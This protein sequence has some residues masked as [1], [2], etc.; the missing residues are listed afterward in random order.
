MEYLSTIEL[1][2][3]VLKTIERKRDKEIH[4]GLVGVPSGFISL[5]NLVLGWK[6]SDL[7]VFAA[8]PSM[9]KTS[10]ILQIARNII[11]NEIPV[12]FFTLE[13]S[14]N[15]LVMKLLSME[16]ELPLNKIQ[17]GKLNDDER[18]VITKKC[19]ELFPEDYFYLNFEDR[20][21]DL[22]DI[23]GV[24]QSFKKKNRNGVIFMDNLQQIINTSKI[25]STRDHEIGDIVREL[26]SLAKELDMPIIITSQMNRGIEY[27]S[28]N[29][30]RP[31]F[32]DLKD[33]G[34]IENVSDIVC[35]IHRPECYKIYEDANGNSLRG[36]AEVIVAKNRSGAVGDVRLR[37]ICEYAKFANLNEGSALEFNKLNYK[38]MTTTTGQKGVL[39]YGDEEEFI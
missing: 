9:G 22:K 11:E 34:E 6:K 39:I 32:V 31:T 10:L 26:K 28:G 19:V 29:E 27:R 25:Y 17:M 7:I 14:A 35:F 30:R 24:C 23:I 15:Q 18:S 8:P 12:L 38:E 3:D 4:S 16:C 33:S 20:Y 36:I 5:D 2:K 1:V 37:F 21:R 13:T